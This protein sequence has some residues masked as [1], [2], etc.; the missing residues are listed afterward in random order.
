MSLLQQDNT[1]LDDAAR[2]ESF[3]KGTSHVTIAA[4][5]A[6]VVVSLAIAVYVIAGEKPPVVTGEILSVTAHSMH[7]LTA[8]R[9]ANGAPIPQESFDQVYVFTHVRLHNQSKGPVFLS[10]MLT[11]ATL[12]DGI[13]SS[14]AASASDYERIFVA[15]PGLPVPHDKA[16]TLDTTIDSG[17][18]VEGTLVSA[19][20]LTK[21]E[22]D[23]RKDLNFTFGF[24]Y[25]PNLVLAPHLAV[26]DR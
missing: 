23:A 20:R 12:A 4:V 26:I 24:R 15:Y 25:Q 7:T 13:H 2:G 6:T 5:A 16:L 1:E 17:Q 10:S 9:D 22:W 14:Y 18:T 21:E 11:N 19:F 3:T 8:G